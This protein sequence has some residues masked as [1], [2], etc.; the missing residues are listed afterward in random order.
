MKR[1]FSERSKKEVQTGIKQ[2]THTYTYVQIYEVVG[3]KKRKYKGLE[4]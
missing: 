1:E 2:H 4:R 3:E